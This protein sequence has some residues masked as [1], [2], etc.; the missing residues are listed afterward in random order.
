MIFDRW[1]APD[2]DSPTLTEYAVKVDLNEQLRTLL[3]MEGRAGTREQEVLEATGVAVSRPRRWHKFFERMGLLYQ[4]HEGKTQLTDLGRLMADIQQT[5]DRQ[6]RRNLARSAIRILRKY[7]LKNPADETDDDKYPDDCDIHPYWALWKAT[8]ELER[9][10]HWDELNREIMWVL[11][12]QELPEAIERIRQAREQPDYDPRSGG[13]STIRL[14]DRCYESSGASEGRD[15][16]GQIRDHITTPWFKRAGFGELL[17]LSPGASGQGYWTIPTDL[18]DVF[19]EEVRTPP[20]FKRFDSQGEWFAYYGKFEDEPAP[21]P[22]SPELQQV[23]KWIDLLLERYNVIF[24]GPPGTG[25]TYTALAID[26]EWTRRYGLNS[27][28][29]VTFHPSYGYEDFVQGFRPAE[30]KPEQFELKP[31]ALLLASERALA[32]ADDGRVLLIIDEINRGDVSRIFGELITYIDSD[33]RGVTFSLAQSPGK[34]F[35]IPGNLFFLGTMNTADRSISLLDVALRRRFAFVEFPPDRRAFDALSGWRREVAG[36]SL[37]ELLSTLNKRLLAEGI[38]PDRAIGHGLLRI[39]TIAKDP[40]GELRRRFR[41]DI[42]PLI[43]EYCYLDRSRIRRILGP[44]VDEEGRLPEVSDGGFLA[45][46]AELAG[47]QLPPPAE[48][49]S[50]AADQRTPEQTH[51]NEETQEPGSS[52]T[53]V[54]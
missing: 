17:L 46:V 50:S 41:Y 45:A 9:K 26:G 19:E 7:Q 29:R 44:L 8:F 13:S 21:V 47:V 39:S 52:T 15:P 30:T 28:F 1:Q 37:G 31:G 22:P 38:E 14:Q 33:K 54:T 2:R 48:T 4:D 36:I 11:R 20:V 42:V 53:F 34:R 32:I 49:S 27:V 23:G 40:I 24:Y 5:A 10:I 18:V 3:R 6:F 43:H 51:K 16:E 35:Q 25:K 12:R